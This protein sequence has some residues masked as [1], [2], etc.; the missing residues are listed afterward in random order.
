M[1]NYFIKIQGL[2]YS[3]RLSML[4]SHLVK[5]AP[6]Y[7][8]V[9]ASLQIACKLKGWPISLSGSVFSIQS[10]CRD[11]SR[12][13][14][15]FYDTLIRCYSD[16]KVG[17]AYQTFLKSRRW[18]RKTYVIKIRFDGVN[19]LGLVIGGKPFV[20]SSVGPDGARDQVAEM[21]TR[22]PWNMNYW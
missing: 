12:D 1:R 15:Y 22:R 21:L 4:E 7:I 11:N 16:L 17:L 9:A 13:N 14:T 2:E 20:Q 8:W 6:E 5:N 3:E 10:N 19:S 18:R